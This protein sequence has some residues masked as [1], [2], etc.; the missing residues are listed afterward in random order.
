[1]IFLSFLIFD[2]W[3]LF[4]VVVTFAPPLPF[5]SHRMTGSTTQPSLRLRRVQRDASTVRMLSS[6]FPWPARVKAR[7]ASTAPVSTLCL[8]GPSTPIT[9]WLGRWFLP[10]RPDHPLMS[11]WV[12]ANQNKYEWRGTATT[13]LTGFVLPCFSKMWSR[14]KSFFCS[15]K[16]K[17][18]YF[19][20][21]QDF[22]MSKIHLCE[23]HL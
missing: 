22:F 18:W 8:P 7:P 4:Q 20:A 5:A 6:V 9:A 2:L 23:A 11:W 1:M 16:A 12:R 10:Y 17:T 14:I 21:N 19:T 13:Y 3:L 15:L